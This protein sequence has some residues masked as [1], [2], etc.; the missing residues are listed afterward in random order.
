M[1]NMTTAAQQRA[2]VSDLYSGRGWKHRVSKMP[3][4]Q[5]TA[6][7]LKHQSDGDPPE[8]YSDEPEEALDFPESA[9]P[10]PVHTAGPHANEDNFPIY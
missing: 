5:I 9:L 10:H 2:Y 1:T 4:S 8:A 6:I 7:Y 3:D